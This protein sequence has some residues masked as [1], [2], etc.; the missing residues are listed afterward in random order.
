MK[1]QASSGMRSSS[2]EWA[3]AGG[4]VPQHPQ[5][6]ASAPHG[7]AL[8]LQL[9]SPSPAVS[10]SPDPASMEG[11][12]GSRSQPGA[13]HLGSCGQW[14]AHTPS[15]AGGWQGGRNRKPPFSLLTLSQLPRGLGGKPF[16]AQDSKG[17]SLGVVSLSR[18]TI[19]NCQGRN[20]RGPTFRD[21]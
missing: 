7:P 20:L 9:L 17:P 6:P 11:V 5:L 21:L 13:L 19:R 14:V 12:K 16:L 10:F 2:Q 4:V 15:R 8:L 18:I 3:I 1:A